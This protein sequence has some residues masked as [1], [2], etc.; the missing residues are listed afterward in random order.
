MRDNAE[1]VAAAA[2][3]GNTVFDIHMYGMFNTAAKVNSYLTSFTKRRLPIVIGEFSSQHQWGKPDEDAILAD[4][5]AQDL[6]YLGWFWRGNDKQYSYLD[7][8]NKF[9]SNS[10]T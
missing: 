2:P 1:G 9:D 3:A 5:H 7:P 6:G 4:A 8:A 10:H